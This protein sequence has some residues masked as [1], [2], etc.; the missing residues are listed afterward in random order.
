MTSSAWP[1]RRPPR[2]SS[3]RNK[4][5]PHG[6]SALDQTY[7][8]LALQAGGRVLLPRLVG[9]C[10]RSRQA[11]LDPMLQPS[12]EADA[13]LAMPE[14]CDGWF[15]LFSE[16]MRPATLRRT[17][18]PPTVPACYEDVDLSGGAPTRGSR[19]RLPRRLPQAL[20]FEAKL[21][22]VAM[23]SKSWPDGEERAARCSSMNCVHGH[24]E[25][26]G[27]RCHR[28]A[29][30][31]QRADLVTI[32][33]ARHD[34][35][36][37]A[38]PGPPPDGIP[39]CSQGVRGP[40]ARAPSSRSAPAGSRRRASLEE[41]L[42]NSYRRTGDA[43]HCDVMPGARLACCRR[44][45]EPIFLRGASPRAAG[46]PACAPEGDDELQRRSTELRGNG[47]GPPTRPT[48]G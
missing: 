39:G 38:G 42:V 29:E 36:G 17:S 6:L 20:I 30:R 13:Y 43:M 48:V 41:A 27:E 15:K 47:D 14:G 4:V 37:I 9:L 10:S 40:P 28:A 2:A 1:R 16:W 18:A 24:A 25:P 32:N 12:R 33:G 45:R 35:R 31:R 23:R 5:L 11:D 46:P 8:L 7:L 21:S 22:P 26:D 3:R 44:A 19:R 34:R